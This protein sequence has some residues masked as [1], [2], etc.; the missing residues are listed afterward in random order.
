MIYL[1]FLSII[2]I[3]LHFFLYPLII[4]FKKKEGRKRNAVKNCF[5]YVSYIIP[6]HNEEKIIEKKIRNVFSLNYP[7]EKMEVIV[8]NDHS[9]DESVSIVKKLILEFEGLKLIDVK[10]RGGKV[11]VQNEAAKVSNGEILVFSD[12]NTMWDRDSLK[13]LISCLNERGISCA[14]GRIIYTNE[15]ESEVSSS[16]GLYWKLE[17]KLKE[18][19]SNFYSLTAINGGIYAIRR[20]DYIFLNPMFSHDIAFPILLAKKKERTIFCKNALA[21]ERSGTTMRDEW[22][23]KTRMFG[24]IY[25]FMFKNPLLFLN[26]FFYDLK[27]YFSLFSHRIIRYTLPLWH[28]LLFISSAFLIREDIIFNLFFHLQVLF[29]IFSLL[30][31]FFGK[32]IKILNLFL[33]YTVFILSMIVGFVNFVTGRVKPYWE[34]AKTTREEAV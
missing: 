20:K 16:E 24:R 27:F 29:I 28:V 19:E 25:Y 4:S 23:R 34:V 30:G 10:K 13:K 11:N 12:A 22:K 26:P 21:F 9:T 1:F 32:K 6:V 33:Y 15:R 17:N 14:C 7:K 2:L 5:P 31:Y 3:I 8:A 18:F